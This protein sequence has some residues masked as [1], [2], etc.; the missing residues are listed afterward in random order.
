MI[1]ESHKSYLTSLRDQI[2]SLRIVK[3]RMAH[4][5]IVA[6]PNS[7]QVA[8]DELPSLAFRRIGLCNPNERNERLGCSHT[9]ARI[10]LERAINELKPTETDQFSQELN[11]LA[12]EIHLLDH[13]KGDAEARLAAAER[14]TDFERM[15]R[16]F[17]EVSQLEQ[18]HDE[19]VERVGGLRDRLLSEIDQM[20]ES[21][22]HAQC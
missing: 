16:V 10:K 3:C 6:L 19:Y 5:R 9:M 8:L 14:E 4:E 13:R 21:F 18:L 22:P 11:W 17:E 1:T 15:K 7:N 2:A 20:I 12:N